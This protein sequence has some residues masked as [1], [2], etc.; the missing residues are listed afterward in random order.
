[1]LC[2]QDTVS[3][4]QAFFERFYKK[5]NVNRIPVSGCIEL[6][7]R[8]NLNCVHCYL[9]SGLRGGGGHAELS[10]ARWMELI[11]QITDAGC[12][13]L[14]F[15][16]GEAILRPDFLEIYTYAC[17]K[18]L[19]ITVFTNATRIS[20]AVIEVFKAYPPRSIEVSLY[21]ATAE[22]YEK[23]TRVSG[24]YEKCR[25]GIYALKDHGFR[26]S[27]KTM[28]MNLNIHELEQMEALAAELEVPF[29]FDAMISP[30]LDGDQAPLTFRV[31]PEQAVTKDFAR[32]K[33][34]KELCDFFHRMNQ[35]DGS[36]D[37]YICGAG[38]N[39]F[40]INAAGRLLP[41]LMT[42]GE[43][44]DLS[45]RYF[46]DVWR[47]EAFKK[48]NQGKKA[49][50]LCEKCDIKMLC[51]YCPG[52]FKLESGSEQAPSEYLCAIGRERRSAILKTGAEGKQ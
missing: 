7:S 29:R 8:C 38:L 21:G 34:A 23:I 47:S 27:L 31:S 44:H 42:V 14:L 49:P 3:H 45:G 48:F 2:G 37:L 24:S 5:V 11:D 19:L 16:G 13:F 15:T 50:A 46:E 22:T 18:G 51:G 43:N 12:L 28:L 20:D 41:C 33:R 4:T 39:M 1:M 17:K 26:F 36:T 30:R 25:R 9:H 32:H 10:T 6:T 40:Y 35:R 52:F